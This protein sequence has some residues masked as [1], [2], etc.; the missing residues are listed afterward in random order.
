MMHR[1]GITT[2]RFR[3]DGKALLTTSQDG[4]AR[5][6]DAATGLPLGPALYHRG[7]VVLGGFSH[8]GKTVVTTGADGT[9]CLWDDAGTSAT[10]VTAGRPIRDWRSRI[11]EPGWG[12]GA[13]QDILEVGPAASTS[14][15]P[16]SRS[17]LADSETR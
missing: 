3:T 8:D 7:A 5:L 17:P 4:T 14:D 9:V 6:W 15:R 16:A 13:R 12:M 1:G 11:L 10:G 2:L